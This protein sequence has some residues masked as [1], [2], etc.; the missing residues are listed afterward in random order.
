M[1]NK[2]DK[3]PAIVRRYKKGAD[4]KAPGEILIIFPREPG[5]PDPSTCECWQWMGQHGHG[6]YNTMIA[7]TNPVPKDEAESELARYMRTLPYPE[8]CGAGYYTAQRATPKDHK[9]RRDELA[10]QRAR[11][12]ANRFRL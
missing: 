10:A 6:D 7:I 1:T 11:A 3:T 5:T 12:I 4:G 8:L 9:A 2:K